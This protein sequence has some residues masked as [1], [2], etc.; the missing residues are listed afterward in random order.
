MIYKFGHLFLCATN[1]SYNAILQIFSEFCKHP[2]LD[3]TACYINTLYCLYYFV[4]LASISP[5]NFI[6]IKTIPFKNFAILLYI[7]FY[8]QWPLEPSCVSK[9]HLH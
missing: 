3:T 2:W 7:Y 4:S 6:L 5:N 1:I 8:V 9:A